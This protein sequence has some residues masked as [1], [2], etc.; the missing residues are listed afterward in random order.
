MLGGAKAS[1]EA[2]LEKERRERE[3]LEK[4]TTA[5]IKYLSKAS[6]NAVQAEKE[7]RVADNEAASIAL[8][9]KE[10]EV[11]AAAKKLLAKE[12]KAA[13]LAEKV[14]ALESD[15][16][17]LGEELQDVADEKREEDAEVLIYIPFIF[18]SYI[19]SLMLPLL[20]SLTF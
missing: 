17:A 11:K 8:A 13:L 2:K 4:H 6:Y 3:S 20:L 9:K 12:R 18:N 16:S 1:A 5:N 14:A 7:K 10:E 19:R 15:C